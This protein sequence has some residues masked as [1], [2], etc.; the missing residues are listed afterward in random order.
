LNIKAALASTSKVQVRAD[1]LAVGEEGR[2]KIVKEGVPVAGLVA[3]HPEIEPMV[4]N[5]SRH[6]VVPIYYNDV[7]VKFQ[8]ASLQCLVSVGMFVRVWSQLEYPPKSNPES[9]H[10]GYQ[11]YEAQQSLQYAFDSVHLNPPVY[12]RFDQILA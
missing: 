10:D 4:E 5:P 8:R 1:I 9:N 2:K 11:R 12:S 7:L 6:V 3:I